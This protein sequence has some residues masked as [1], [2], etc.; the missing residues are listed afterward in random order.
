[1]PPGKSTHRW[2][3]QSQAPTAATVRRRAKAATARRK[4]NSQTKLTRN[5]GEQ[6]VFEAAH[7]RTGSARSRSR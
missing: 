5:E 6:M 3:L 1:M 7:Q 4:G 2:A